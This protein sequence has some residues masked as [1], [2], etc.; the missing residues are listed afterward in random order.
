[1]YVQKYYFHSFSLNFTFFFFFFHSTLLASVSQQSKTTSAQD[2][3][4][5]LRD[6][7]AKSNSTKIPTNSVIAKPDTLTLSNVPEL[8]VV[9]PPVALPNTNLLSK[10]SSNNDIRSRLDRIKSTIGK[11]TSQNSEMK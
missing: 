6:L 11:T 9:Q 1:M 8:S 4:Q 3:R 7:Q 2:L 5:R 10:S